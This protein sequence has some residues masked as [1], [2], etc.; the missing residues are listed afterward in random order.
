MPA[1]ASRLRTALGTWATQVVAAAGPETAR[2]AQRDPRVPVGDS[3]EL[4]GSIRSL[5]DVKVGGTRRSV[6]VVA[7]VIQ[8]AT[9]DKGARAHRIVP[10]RAGG[11]LVF[12]WPKAGGTVFLRSVNHP[13]NP[14]RP[15]WEA[16]I[17][18]A[19]RQ[20]LRTAAR[21]TSF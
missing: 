21:R 1:D 6:T 7:P 13:G 17:R 12:H 20:A 19:W 18:D 14:P 5:N 8:A 10:R 11:L 9:T 3:R 15:W 4:V 2:I 16:V